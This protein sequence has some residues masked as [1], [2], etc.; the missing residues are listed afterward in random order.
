VN[1]NDGGLQEA[2]D[3]ACSMEKSAQQFLFLWWVLATERLKRLK[4]ESPHPVPPLRNGESLPEWVLAIQNHV[5]RVENLTLLIM[6]AQ[7]YLGHPLRKIDP[8]KQQYLKR[9]IAEQ[10]IRAAVQ[11]DC[12][13]EE[14]ANWI[15][16]FLTPSTK[17]KDRR[18]KGAVANNRVVLLALVLNEKH[19][20]TWNFPKL[21][22][23][24]LGCKAHEEHKWDTSCTRSLAKAVERL[25]TF[26]A[27]LGY[28][29]TAT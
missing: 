1:P 27:E 9:L 23:Q 6:R 28:K 26:L 4:D 2:L 5:N 3:L 11:G 29:P 17:G 20:D 24:L 10:W 12:S 13:N 25:R 19:P 22:D 21:A 8:Q 14:I 18:P 7:G 16:A 15:S